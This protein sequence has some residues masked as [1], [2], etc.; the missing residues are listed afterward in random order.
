MVSVDEEQPELFKIKLRFPPPPDD[1]EDSSPLLEEHASLVVFA[2]YS[3]ANGQ[4]YH[5]H[6]WPIEERRK[7]N[8]YR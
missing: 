6:K 5:P 7:L 4:P 1:I 8:K 3:K 2:R